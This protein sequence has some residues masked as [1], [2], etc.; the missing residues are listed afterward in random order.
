MQLFLVAC[1][2]S[3]LFTTTLAAWIPT[4]EFLK[5]NLKRLPREGKCVFYTSRLSEE[6]KKYAGSVDKDTIWDIWPPGYYDP[7]DW[8]QRTFEN[9]GER[10]S[11]F[12]NMSRAYA[13]LC[14]G[15]A[16]VMIPGNTKP[17][18]DSIWLED[19][20]DA[21]SKGQTGITEVTRIDTDGS[22]KG[23]YEGFFT[24]PP[25]SRSKRRS[26]KREAAPRNVVNF[27]KLGSSLNEPD[28]CKDPNRFKGTDP[29]NYIG[30]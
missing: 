3:S 16:W 20:W 14:K 27:D 13:Q 21:I 5:Q 24:R 30:N 19:E 9:D 15:S 23:P 25:V 29:N 28:F 6:A 11:Y 22:E 18:S 10:R 26:L 7:K 17:C 2:A 4:V 12:K 8:P 1:L